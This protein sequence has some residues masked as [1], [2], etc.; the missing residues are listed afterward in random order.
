MRRCGNIFFPM[1]SPVH[2]C[3]FPLST[4]PPVHMRGGLVS[5]PRAVLTVSSNTM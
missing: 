1:G 5:F 3:S 4:A 2:V